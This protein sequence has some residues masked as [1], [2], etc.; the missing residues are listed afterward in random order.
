MFDGYN[1]L[2]QPYDFDPRPGYPL[3]FVTVEEGPRP[4]EDQAPAYKLL[5]T[6]LYKSRALR[7]IYGRSQADIL[8][9]GGQ[10]A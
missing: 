8:G 1:D 5:A 10:G 4:L 2:S 6:L 9:A 3:N 7:V